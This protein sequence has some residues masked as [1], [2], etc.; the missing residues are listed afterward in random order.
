[1]ATVTARAHPNI[2]LVKY[3]GKRDP[4]LNLPAVGSISVTLSDME[5]ETEVT[6][7]PSAEADRFTLDGASAPAEA[8]RVGRFLDRVRE[9]AGIETHACVSSRNNFPTAAGLASSASGFAA[10][11]VAATRAAGLALDDRELSVLARL[12]SGS[13][14]RSLFGGFV[15]MSAGRSTSGAD[16]VARQLH[17]PRHWPLTVRVAITASGRKQ[18]GSTEAMQL[19]ERTSPFYGAWVERNAADLDEA[20]AAIAHRD[21]ERLARVTEAS[22]LSMHAVALSSEPGLLFWNGTT[23]RVIH[24]VRAARARG[25]PVFFTIDA[26]PQVKVFSEAGTSFALE[27]V[28]GVEQVIE[29]GV[30]PGAEVV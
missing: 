3:W 17:P 10:L 21:L 19:S 23:V 22:C 24:E 6:L 29:V 15:E 26:G 11:T 16:A 5:T 27:Q 9:R 7:D 28:H 2:A 4:V 14:P 18:V 8:A 1:M 12:G 30:G 13:A 25:L 20:R